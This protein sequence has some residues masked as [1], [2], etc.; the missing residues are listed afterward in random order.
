MNLKTPTDASST[1]IPQ[2]LFI[3]VLAGPPN[4]P[5]ARITLTQNWEGTPTRALS[6]IISLS[7]NTFPSDFDGKKIYDYMIANNLVVTKD[8]KEF[9]LYKF[10][11]QFKKLY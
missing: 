2:R 5:V 11:E 6:D 4:Q 9:G 3:L 7:Y 1:V 10:I 8:E